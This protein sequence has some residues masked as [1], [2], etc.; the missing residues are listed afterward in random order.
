[1]Q[2]I[3]LRSGSCAQLLLCRVLQRALVK[4]VGFIKVT[5]SMLE[6]IG[7]VV[8]M[9]SLMVVFVFVFEGRTE[10]GEALHLL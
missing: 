1:M 3:E 2:V 5:V 7:S 9:G 4:V 6:L 8:V 10:P